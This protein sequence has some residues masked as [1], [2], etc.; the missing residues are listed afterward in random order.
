MAKVVLRDVLIG[1]WTHQNPQA[2]R[3][4]R[5]FDTSVPDLQSRLGKL[6]NQPMFQ[7]ERDSYRLSRTGFVE[8]NGSSVIWRSVSV[9]RHLGNLRDKGTTRKVDAVKFTNRPLDG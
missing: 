4:V 8:P 7:L 1:L 5:E 6:F 3:A 2:F 9:Q